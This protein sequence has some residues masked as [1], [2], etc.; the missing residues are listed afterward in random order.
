MFKR[1]RF[2]VGAVAFAVTALTGTAAGAACT[3]TSQPSLAILSPKTGAEV[4]GQLVVRYRVTSLKVGPAR[5]A[6]LRVSLPGVDQPVRSVMRMTTAAGTVTVPIS[7]LETGQRDLRFTLLRANR[8]AADSV[9]VRDVLI[10]G[11]RT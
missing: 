4:E 3:T 6:Y 5:P 8:T 9:L 1:S 2:V 10:T 7:K 11:G